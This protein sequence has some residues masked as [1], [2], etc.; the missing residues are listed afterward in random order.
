[1]A[2]GIKKATPRKPINKKVRGSVK[3]NWTMKEKRELA[4]L[5]GRN[6]YSESQWKLLNKK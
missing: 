3:G 2:T 5:L 6:F 4:K 1:M